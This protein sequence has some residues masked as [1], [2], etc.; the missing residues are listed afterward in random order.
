MR[1]VFYYWLFAWIVVI[2][3]IAQKAHS[4]SL[5]QQ[6]FPELSRLVKEGFLPNY[7]VVVVDSEGQLTTQ[8]ESYEGGVVS[9]DA[10]KTTSTVALLSLSKPITNLLALRLV[11]LGYLALD[12]PVSKY[13][14]KFEDPRMQS[15]DQASSD[16]LRAISIRDL[17]IHTA[18]FAQNAELL[19]WG[20]V[21]N[22]YA[23][24]AIFGFDCLNHDAQETLAQITD[25]LAGLPLASE[26][27]KKFAYS[28]ATDVLGRVLE[29]AAGES[30][31]VL[32][33]KHISIPLAMPGLTARITGKR[34]ADIAQLYQPLIKTYPVPGAYQR[35]EPFT[36]IDGNF[37]GDDL[38]EVCISPGSGLFASMNDM[39]V[40][41]EFLRN[42]LVLKNG[43]PF[44]SESLGEQVFEHALD[45]SFGNRP[46]RRSLAYAGKD[47][48]S[49]A[50]LA[51]RPKN[52]LG[53]AL[54]NEHDFY[55]WSGFSGSG[56]WIDRSNNTAGV[57]LTQLYPSDQFLIPKL[58]G[59]VRASL[60]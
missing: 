50:S 32:L 16:A 41:I 19:G 15:T 54:E 57:L 2:A 51:I 25:R 47:G 21:A 43:E 31:D 58:V 35:Y 1:Q 23:E 27:G 10:I 4:A 13:L 36:G 39:V 33:R 11:T 12:E 49:I 52:G 28:V 40:F 42:D 5:A 24:Q 45:A 20:E 38:E 14:P 9:V 53:L 3:P 22:T 59:K 46:L 6:P 48:I 7:H 44:L 29:V 8:A 55:Y 18:G 37:S 56:I 26:P 30:F 34:L 17:L 60:K